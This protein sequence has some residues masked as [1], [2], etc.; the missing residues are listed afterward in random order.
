[1]KITLQQLR[2]VIREEI[3]RLTEA[4]DPEIVA[5]DGKV[6]I[7]IGN[8][9]FDFS[10]DKVSS[11]IKKPLWSVNSDDFD[12]EEE[13]GATIMKTGKSSPPDIAVF[14]K[15]ARVAGDKI[16]EEELKNALSGV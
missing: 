11:V 7:T 13:T 12:D 9:M 6:Q 15:G 16:D 3:V 14:E 10:P 5:K 8:Q 4:A 1:M 2:R